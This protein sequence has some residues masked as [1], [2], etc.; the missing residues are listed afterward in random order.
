MRRIC[1]IKKHNLI[2]FIIKIKQSKLNRFESRD[3][4]EVFRNETPYRVYRGG[5]VTKGASISPSAMEG[6]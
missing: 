4:R 5:G 1:F 6:G 2:Q 3:I